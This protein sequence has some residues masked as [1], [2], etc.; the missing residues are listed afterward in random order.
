MS[1]E[2]INR[3]GYK[4]IMDAIYKTLILRKK[5]K[6]CCVWIYGPT[7]TGKTKIAKILQEIFITEQYLA[8]FTN[9][10]VKTNENKENT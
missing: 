5:P 10:H 2:V 1:D 6:K 3:L 4:Q 8:P 7:N 9:F